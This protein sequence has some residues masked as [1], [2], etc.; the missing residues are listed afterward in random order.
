MPLLL[1][2]LLF[3]CVLQDLQEYLSLLGS[4]LPARGTVCLWH[5]NLQMQVRCCFCGV[6]WAAAPEKSLRHLC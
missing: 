5:Q 4:M 6:P 1:L 3:L 2:L